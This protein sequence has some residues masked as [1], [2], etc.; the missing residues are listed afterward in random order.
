MPCISGV[1]RILIRGR[2]FL[3][4]K[5]T[6]AVV[7][8]A[9]VLATV[10]V[11]IALRHKHEA[12]HYRTVMVQRG[13]VTATVTATGTLSAV[14]TVA[15]GSQVSGQISH[16]YADFNDHVRAG[17]VIAL[18]DT[19]LLAEQVNSARSDVAKAQADLDNKHYLYAQADSLYR[20]RLMAEAD[21]RTALFNYRTSQANLQ[22]SQSAL[23]R[24][25][26]N[27]RYSVIRS[28][29]EGVVIERDVDVGQTVAAS[30]QAPQLFL[31]AQDLTRMQIL[32]SVDESDIGRIHDG[33]D[34]QFTVQAYPTRKYMGTVSQ[35]RLQSKTDQNVVS[36]TVVV[37]VNNQDKTLLPGMT[38][39]VN[40][41]VAQANDVLT[42]SNAALRFHAPAELLAKIPG[43]SAADTAG[44]RMRRGGADT[45]RARTDSLRPSAPPE[46]LPGRV[47]SDSAVQAANARTGRG[48]S[49][50]PAFTMRNGG[51]QSQGSF[52]RL[53]YVD[54][55]GN[56]QVLRVRVGISDGQKSEIMSR[57][58]S[59]KD[60]LAVITGILEPGQTQARAGT[61]ASPF[62]QQQQRRGPGGF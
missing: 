20:A 56:P 62:E 54:A 59:L 23:A 47:R 22:S 58:S 25:E 28:P 5:T 18:I 45:T 53:F 51:P 33:Q 37:A 21:Y 14:R 55:A 38:A 43:M 50:Q 10:G 26:Q 36:Y 29:I 49:Q 7:A 30:F 17:Q 13:S 41:I 16:L 40:F 46:S 3:T 27:L 6:L 32:V 52:A 60:G 35:V 34:V 24:A 2:V 44:F 15:V 19:T 31:I 8:A 4:M 12:Q 1:R 9:G 11:G 61:A 39:T 42:V 48:P 57:D